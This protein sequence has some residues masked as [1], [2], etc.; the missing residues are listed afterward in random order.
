MFFKVL[1]TS[2]M[3]FIKNHMEKKILALIKNN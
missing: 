2:K 3:K 1:K